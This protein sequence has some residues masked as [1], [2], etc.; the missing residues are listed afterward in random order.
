MQRLSGQVFSQLAGVVPPAPHANH[1]LAVQRSNQ[2]F[3]LDEA[4]FIT[5]GVGETLG[6]PDP[7][8]AEWK[9]RI[10]AW[11]SQLAEGIEPAEIASATADAGLRP[12][13]SRDQMVLQWTFITAGLAQLMR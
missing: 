10:D 8:A 11:R 1:H 5:P 9:E 3:H 6:P 12:M 4:V 13:P 2:R 7:V